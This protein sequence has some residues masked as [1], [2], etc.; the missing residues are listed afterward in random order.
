MFTFSVKDIELLKFISQINELAERSGDENRNDF[1][2]YSRIQDT[3]V[4]QKLG[5]YIDL[6]SKVFLYDD[7]KPIDGPL[8]MTLYRLVRQIII[9]PKNEKIISYYDNIF[10]QD[11]NNEP[12]CLVAYPNMDNDYDCIYIEDGEW[13]FYPELESG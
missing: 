7:T 3:D 6:T 2:G 8:G 12:L 10:V 13:F 9:M 1:L 4:I 5:G 11:N